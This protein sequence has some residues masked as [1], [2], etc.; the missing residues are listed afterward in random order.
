MRFWEIEELRRGEATAQ[1]KIPLLPRACAEI[2]YSFYESTEDYNRNV[3]LYAVHSIGG[4][5]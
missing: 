2:T 1:Q 3:C 4:D 5:E